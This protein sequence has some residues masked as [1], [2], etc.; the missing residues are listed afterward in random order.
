MNEETVTREQAQE[1]IE[2]L[3]QIRDKLD[4]LVAFAGMH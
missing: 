3:K 4:T 2:L 1:M